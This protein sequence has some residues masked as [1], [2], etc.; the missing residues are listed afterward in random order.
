MLSKLAGKPLTYYLIFAAS[1]F[2]GL[3]Y[4]SIWTRYLKLILGHAAYAQALVLVIFLLGLAVGS[5]ACARVSRR[6]SRPLL[7]YALIEAVV[8]L[9]ALFFHEI[10]VAARSWLAVSVLAGL[11]TDTAA[12]LAKWTLA[13]VLI[14]PQSVLLGATFP[15]MSAGLA[16]R[17][18]GNTGLVVSMLYFTNSLGAALGVL[19]SGLL[20]VPAVGLPGTSIA[21]G[22][23]NLAA[24]AAVWLLVRRRDEAPPALA[25]TR[26]TNAAEAPAAWRTLILSVSLA[27]GL[28]SF[29]YELVWIR[30]LSLLLGSSTHSFEVMLAAFILGLA[31][32]GYAVR[33]KADRIGE[34]MHLLAGVQLAMGACALLSLFMFPLIYEMLRTI[35]SEIERNAAGYRIYVGLSMALAMLMMLPATFCAG[36]TLPLLTKRL[37]LHGGETAIG[38]VYAANTFGAI[39]G[40][41]LTL[42]FL[43]PELGI[44]GA[45]LVGGAVDLVLGVAI[46]AFLRRI[47]A[48]A[49][50]AGLAASVLLLAFGFGTIDPRI[51]AA[52]VFRSQNEFEGEVVFY[53][54][55]KTASISVVSHKHG[56]DLEHRSIRTNGKPDAALYYHGRPADA[57]PL[58]EPTMT[59]LGLYPLLFRPD[60]QAAL[61]IGF[62]AGLTSRTLL[63]SD[64]LK[65]LDNVEIEPVMIEGAKQLGER[66]AP[67]FS[68]K[69][70][71]FIFDDAKT[72]LSRTTGKYDI[73]V[74][75]PSNPWVSGIAGL[76]TRE[77]YADVAGA[78]AADGVFIQWYHTYESSPHLFASIAKALATAFSSF[79]VF[80]AN[81]ADLIIV[82]VKE[83]S[84]P[85]MRE[86]I[87]ENA[88]AREFLERHGYRSTADIRISEIGDDKLL[89]PYLDHF[90]APANS[91]YFPYLE[92]HAPLAFFLRK[93][94]SLPLVPTLEVP[95]LEIISGVR[96]T[97]RRE[98]TPTRKLAIAE[99][100]VAA[101]KLYRKRLQP[102]SLVQ[103]QLAELGLLDCATGTGQDAA[104]LIIKS[105]FDSFMPST[106]A[107]QMREVW[108]LIEPHNCSRMLLAAGNESEAAVLTRLL[109]GTSRRDYRQ[110]IEAG[111]RLLEMAER[112]GVSR[113]EYMQTAFLATLAGH[114]AVG[115]YATVAGYRKQEGLSVFAG[116]AEIMLR[117]AAGR[118]LEEESR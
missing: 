10:F 25:G 101:Q 39:C 23:I 80:A 28:A 34:P 105:L 49:F 6:I 53:R 103:E 33:R 50:G 29:I 81:D 78:L 68:D 65:R 13:A 18:P 22:L 91:D 43:L 9:A 42:H 107:D 7:A 24:A 115:D 30:M 90:D 73:I 95:V 110:M 116:H 79:R 88:G 31:L 66:I 54:E 98:L 4:E 62:G 51:A 102:D 3:I 85:A 118:R 56:T 89:L 32:G 77:F 93:V 52:G 5:A 12:T 117:S 106:P 40:V 38:S 63:L 59:S 11:E 2:S 35:L 94:Y 47:P 113:Q 19:A 36:M 58:D 16:R 74:S 57:N 104:A 48:A 44:Q 86:D 111:E 71:R 70:S 15:L 84:L 99:K 97:G 87:F 46:L 37:M 1:G 61:N 55:G 41:F 8:A 14:F 26:H 20:L 72:V 76:Y 100:A 96:T 75:E 112:A 109:R 108:E 69:R 82:A 92:S 114:Y 67:V 60:A 64:S 83:G 17:W 21:A 27:T 45:M